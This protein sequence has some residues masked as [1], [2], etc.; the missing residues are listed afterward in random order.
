METNIYSAP[1]AEVEKTTVFCREC[2][3]KL[4]KTAVACTQ[5]G[6]VQDVGGKSKVAAGLL[7]I[8]L[9]G[10]GFHR[11]YLG[12][13]WGIFY[14]LLFWTWIPGII[15]FI[16]GIVFLCTSQQTWLKKYGNTKGTSGLV[17]VL[18]SVLVIIPAIGILAA[19][20]LPAY[21]DYVVRAE[22]MQQQ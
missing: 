9:G 6:A 11:F 4:S 20:A 5:C 18:V 16:E 2:G 14:L 17:L 15:A 7:A 1:E 3:A 10:F 22:Q 13:W 21:Q 12:Q 8:F 19:I